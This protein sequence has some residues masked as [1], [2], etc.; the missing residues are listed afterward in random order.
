MSVVLSSG[1]LANGAT[2]GVSLKHPRV[3]IDDLFRDGTVT[4]SSEA[5]D[6]PK[7]NATDGLDWDWWEPT[8]VPAWIQV[9]AG[10]AQAVTY[11]GIAAHDLGTQ[12]C[13]VTPQYSSDGSTWSDAT[14]AHSPSDDTPIMFLFEEVSA[15]YWRLYIS[16]GSA[17]QL[18]VV[19]VGKSLD[20]Q[21]A[22]YQGHS[23]LPLSRQTDVRPNRA[24]GGARLGRSIIRR[25]V[26]TSVQFQNLKADWVRSELDPFIK[27]ARTYAFF[28]AWRPTTYPDEVGWVW[29]NGDIV[30]ENS[31]PADRMSVSFDVQGIANG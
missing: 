25:G 2:S 27:L 22:L 15:R 4:A 7:E 24:E 3:G 26:A 11:M 21:R 18:A 12:G 13:S 23:P 5:A 19:Q 6:H 1:I 17:P 9:D 16:G 20:F 30:P 31:G 28:F 29:V 14:S 8:G 10:S